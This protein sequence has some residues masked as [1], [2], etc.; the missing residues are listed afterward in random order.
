MATSELPNQP[1][2]HAGQGLPSDLHQLGPLIQVVVGPDLDDIPV[3]KANGI[4]VITAQILLMIDTGALHTVIEDRVAQG[5]NLRPVRHEPI[6]GISQKPE[7]CPIYQMSILIALDTEIRNECRY[8]NVFMA[9][10][11]GVPSPPV[12]LPHAGLLGRDFL[13]MVKLT[14][15]GPAGRWEISDSRHV[16]PSSSGKAARHGRRK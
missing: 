1:L 16:R 14:Y 9:D 5:M 11:A 8:R 4:E 15:D 10:V 7:Y 6:V 12:D 13:A 3:M 2:R